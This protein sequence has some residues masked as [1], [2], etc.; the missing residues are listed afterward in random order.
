MVAQ[1]GK[2]IRAIAV[3]GDSGE[4]SISEGGTVAAC[5]PCGGCRQ[6]ILEFSDD[7]TIVLLLDADQKIKVYTIEDLLPAAF[8]VE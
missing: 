5:T 2:V 4:V 7:A 8:R 3:V 1:G 6:K